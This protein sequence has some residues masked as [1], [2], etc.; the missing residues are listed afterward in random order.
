MWRCQNIHMK[1]KPWFIVSLIFFITFVNFIDRSAIS[2]V[3]EPLKR[4]FH[5]TDTDFGMILSAF[6]IGYIL[7]SGVGGWFVDKF[8]K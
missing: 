6:G 3:I 7:L 5:F 2:F 8:G 1:K 4:E